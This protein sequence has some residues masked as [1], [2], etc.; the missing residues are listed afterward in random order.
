MSNDKFVYF[1]EGC[2]FQIICSQ[3]AI[4]PHQAHVIANIGFLAFLKTLKYYRH[5]AI[6]AHRDKGKRNLEQ[7]V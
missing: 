2:G 1:P 5:L 6:I 7:K 3:C 4:S